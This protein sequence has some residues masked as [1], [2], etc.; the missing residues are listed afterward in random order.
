MLKGWSSYRTTALSYK[1][2]IELCSATKPGTSVSTDP[3]GP[4]DPTLVSMSQNLFSTTTSCE[5]RANLVDKWPL[6]FG[7][8]LIETFDFYLITPSAG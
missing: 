1:G 4:S 2:I 8:L 5:K 7:S 6:L 3:N